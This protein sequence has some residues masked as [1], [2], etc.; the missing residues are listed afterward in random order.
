MPFTNR[1]RPFAF[2]LTTAALAAAAAVTLGAQ[3]GTVAAWR[4]QHERAIVDEL[5]QLVAIPNVAGND[6]DMRRNADM[7]ETLFEKRGFTVEVT[8]G[9]GHR[10]CSPPATCRRRAAT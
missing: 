1:L 3:A 2:A 6:A 9:P 10:S 4:A 8:D 5:L 7:L